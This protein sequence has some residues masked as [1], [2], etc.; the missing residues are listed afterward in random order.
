MNRVARRERL[1]AAL[2][3]REP[4]R[5]P[6]HAAEQRAL[7][8]RA[9]PAPTASSAWARESRFLTD[10]R[11]A[12]SVA[13]LAADWQVEIVQQSLLARRRRPLRRAVR[14]RAR[15]LRGVGALLRRLARARRG[16]ARR[17]RRAR[18]LRPPRR[19]PA[20]RQGRRRDRADP[21]AAASCAT[22]STPGSPRTASPAARSAR[23]PG[24]SSSRRA[25]S[26]P[27]ARRSRRSSPRA[28]NGALPHAV[29][30]AL[31][32][33]RSHARRARPRRA[34]RRLLLRLHAHV[35]DGPERRRR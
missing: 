10:F 28:P 22:R 19:G 21:R 16:R 9:T 4:G 1:S 20:R 18:A 3:E 24:R 17:G 14:R 26:A 12:T 29:P 11:Y 2:A 15:R 6:R 13:P 35:R 33:E 30:G 32:I 8:D 5:L 31:E 23:S 27:R 25:S 7:P 34:R